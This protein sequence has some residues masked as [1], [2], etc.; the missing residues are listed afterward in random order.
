MSWN[1]YVKTSVILDR[2]SRT[3]KNVKFTLADIS[4]WCGVVETEY[5]GS[6]SYMVKYKNVPIKVIDYAALLPCNAYRLLTIRLESDGPSYTGYIYDKQK[7]TFNTSVTFTKDD[8]ANDI[9]YAT[10][11][12]IPVDSE[13]GY[14]LVLADHIEVCAAY[15]LKNTYYDDYLQ[16]KI[17]HNRWMVMEQDFDNKLAGASVNNIRFYSD[18]EKQQLSRI[19]YNMIQN[20]HAL[21]DVY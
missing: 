11:K 19:M 1:N 21:P 10:Y 5:L 12:G 14:P 17:D 9:V 16:G 18:K 6:D 20:P 7:L 4:E 2:L 8:N 15:C 3:H 13:T